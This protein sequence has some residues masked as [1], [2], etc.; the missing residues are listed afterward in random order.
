MLFELV[1]GAM[2]DR[3]RR[4][5]VMIVADLM[6]AALLVIV[7]ALALTHHLSIWAL[8]GFMAVF[9]LVS[10]LGDAATQAFTPRLV[11]RLLLISAH[12]RLDQRSAVAQTS[13]PCAGG[14]PGQ[15]DRRTV[16]GSRRCSQLLILGVDAGRNPA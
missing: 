5:P 6:R 8:A 14:R 1:A 10:L 12:A 15:P 2:I 16:G 3:L 7:P 4:R 13:G 11:P 9:G